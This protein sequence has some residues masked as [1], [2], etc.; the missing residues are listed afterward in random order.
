M[1]VFGTSSA[2]QATEKAA[3]AIPN[4]IAKAPVEAAVD[5]LTLKNPVAG[6]QNIVRQ[7]LGDLALWPFRFS[8]H[9]LAGGTKTLLK[10]GWGALIN[11]PVIPF[12]SA[13]KQFLAD[14]SRAVHSMNASLS[15]GK[16]P[17]EA[18]KSMTRPA[19]APPATSA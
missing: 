14:P 12:G 10:L 9:V 11:S 5:M 17:S 4:M 2:G 13:T 3:L 16:S 18:W 19:T 6:I 8:G 7:S 15:A 1:D